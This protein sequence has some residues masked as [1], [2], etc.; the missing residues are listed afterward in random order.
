MVRIFIYIIMLALA[1]A[2]E[3][4]DFS[5]FFVSPSDNVDKRFEQSLKITGDLPV[6]KLDLPD[7][8]VFYVCTDVHVDGTTDN[9]DIFV[10]ELRNDVNSGFALVLGDVS[11]R[12]GM[13]KTFA[14]AITFDPAVHAYDR[15]IFV[16]P[17]NHDM[18]FSQWHDYKSLLGPAVYCF[19]VLTSYGKD[20][21]IALDSASGTLGSRQT[22]WLKELLADKRK[23]YNNCVVFKHTNMF[24]TDNSQNTSGN[25]PLDETFALTD[26]FDRYDVTAVFQGHDHHREDLTYRGVRYTLVGAIKD[27]A[28]KPEY[29]KVTMSEDDMEYEWVML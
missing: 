18:Y 14:S 10:S 21:F 7:D 11:Q 12:K 5:G 23:D 4:A 2:C 26:L 17:G 6:A 1:A 24:K 15:P 20:L 29:F 28:E 13:M 16:I 3:T 9:F 25:M 19:E 27:E 22:K 8:Y